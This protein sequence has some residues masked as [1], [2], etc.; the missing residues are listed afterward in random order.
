MEQTFHDSISANAE[1]FANLAGELPT[2]IQDGDRLVPS[3]ASWWAPRLLI[4]DRIGP[5]SFAERRGP[6]DRPG[7]WVWRSRSNKH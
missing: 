2:A 3:A 7:S 6:L 5:S 4:G 1:T